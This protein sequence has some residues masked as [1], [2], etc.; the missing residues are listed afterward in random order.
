MN[1]KP[2]CALSENNFHKGN[3]GEVGFGSGRWQTPPVFNQAVANVDF[4][5]ATLPL[6]KALAAPPG[7]SGADLYEGCFSR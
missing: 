4:N 3:D 7:V 2:R 6:V 5:R 1:L